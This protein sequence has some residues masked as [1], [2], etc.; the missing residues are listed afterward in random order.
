MTFSEAP[1]HCQPTV[2]QAG[3]HRSKESNL[4]PLPGYDLLPVPPIAQIQLEAWGQRSKLKQ[5]IKVSQRRR[6]TVEAGGGGIWR[7]KW[8]ASSTLALPLIL[9]EE[10][11]KGQQKH[12]LSPEAVLSEGSAAL[13][14]LHTD[15]IVLLL[16][17]RVPQCDLIM[18][19]DT[20]SL[21]SVSPHLA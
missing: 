12:H 15:H 5:S 9:S 16:S 18:S 21:I 11:S 3:N 19:R 17:W 7:S 8:R 6:S 13:R 4:V 10:F 1:H 2:Q 20:I 14:V